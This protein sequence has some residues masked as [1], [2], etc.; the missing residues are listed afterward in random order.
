MHRGRQGYLNRRNW[1]VG[2]S[3]VG[4]KESLGHKAARTVFR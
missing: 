1:S 2:W 3:A 4:F